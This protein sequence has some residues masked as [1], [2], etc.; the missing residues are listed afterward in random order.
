[1]RLQ[2]APLENLLPVGLRV[3]SRDRLLFQ[4]LFWGAMAG[5]LATLLLAESPILE[6]MELSMLEWQYRISNQISALW[7]KPTRSHDI[8]LVDFD[9][10]TQFDHGTLNEAPCQE[11][12]A[13][14]IDRIESANPA[15]VVL[16]LDLR[17]ASTTQL[18]TVM[19][20]YHNIVLALFG[21]LEGSTE[22]PAAD[23]MRYAASFGYDELPRENNGVVCRLPP[24]PTLGATA[25]SGGQDEQTSF[26]PSLTQAVLELYRK[27][28]GVGP[29]YNISQQPEFIDYRDVKYDELALQEV[30]D[31]QLDAKKFKDRIVLIGNKC[32][33]KQAQL[34]TPTRVDP[35]RH[36]TPLQGSVHDM[37]IHAAAIETMLDNQSIKSW[38]R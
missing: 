29:K 4:R 3:Q 18:A 33:P 38:P 7:Q 30:E 16:D 9:D 1:M 14:T 25:S 2:L 36:R 37:D 20:K 21:S 22:L 8:T 35:S 11:W 6:S 34:A 17:G 26:V 10:D 12:L 13:K 31:D 28:K 19:R 23:Y 32:T 24:V 27:V 15:V 5:C